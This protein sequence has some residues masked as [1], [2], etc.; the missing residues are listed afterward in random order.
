MAG[1][2]QT[3]RKTF[4]GITDKYLNWG[5]LPHEFVDVTGTFFQDHL[6]DLHTR[7]LE[8]YKR[9][10]GFYRGEHFTTMTA[11]GTRKFVANYCRLVV[12]KSVTWLSA[13][14]FKLHAPAGNEAILPALNLLWDLNDRNAL[15]VEHAQTGGV[16][17]DA[18]LYPTV[19]DVGPD[20]STLPEDEQR[21]VIV[22]LAP[23]YVY[24]VYNL[25]TRE[26]VECLI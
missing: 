10:W 19:I 24:P 14:G 15:M 5:A 11:E 26:I 21:I 13:N 23:S 1:F 3:V 25:V 7:R 2:F 16:T 8:R 20:G 12:D 18:F 17:G 22:N 4:T 6:R 9:H